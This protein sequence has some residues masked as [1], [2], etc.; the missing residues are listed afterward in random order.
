M[1]VHTIL[2]PEHNSTILEVTKHQ[3]QWKQLRKRLQKQL[4]YYQK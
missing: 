2:A 1:Q 4:K 3:N